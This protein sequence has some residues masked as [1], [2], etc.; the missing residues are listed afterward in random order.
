MGYERDNLYTVVENLAPLPDGRFVLALRESPF[1]AE[2]GGQTADIGTIESDEGKVVVDDVQQHGQVQVIIAR[3]AEGRIE[4]GTRVK[5][6][7]SSAYRHDVAAN[8][9]ATHLLHYALRTRLG[10]EVTQAGSSVRADKFRFDFAYHEPLGPKRLG[11]IEELV[12]RRI[13]EDHP[14]RSFT[15]TIDQARDLGAMALFGEKYDDFVRVV[16]IDDFSREL[17]GGTHVASTTELGIFKIVSESSVGANVRRIEA[18]TGRSAV[19]YYRSRDAVLTTATELLGSPS[20]D[21]IQAVTRLQGQVAQLEA[22]VKTYRAG[23]ARDSAETLIRA[24]E[25]R[26]GVSVVAAVVEVSEMDQ[27]LSLVDRVRDHLA[28]AAIALGAVLN[29]KGTLVVSTSQGVSALDA[30]AVAREAARSFGGGGG[31]NTNLGRA[32]G[33][34]PATLADSVDMARQMLWEGL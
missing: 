1:Y 8:H 32:G 7:F 4:A 24:S 12:N 21:V 25:R 20:L 22:E 28:P 6:A 3:P 29:G 5:A 9:T 31:G 27:L 13:I 14:V 30:G 11:E 10:K 34:E 17:C 16:E 2:G 33:L 23:T 19:A 15:T 26:N 18:I